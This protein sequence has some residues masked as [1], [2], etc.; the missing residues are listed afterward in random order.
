MSTATE[1]L[2]RN[3]ELPKLNQKCEY[4]IDQPVFT[5]QAV[6]KP[7]LNSPGNTMT[8]YRATSANVEGMLECAVAELPQIGDTINITMNGIGPAIVKGYMAEFGMI[9]II[10]EPLGPPEWW[11]KQ[12]AK[13]P[14]SKLFNMCGV[15]FAEF[16]R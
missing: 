13:N 6:K 10:A 2:D 11:K 7:V 5:Q 1:Q 8:W 16:Q 14:N 12:N 3:V 9:G 4:W 15:Y